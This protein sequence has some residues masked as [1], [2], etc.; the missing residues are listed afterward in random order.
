[1][2]EIL[3]W[4]T[5]CC[6]APQSVSAGLLCSKLS[7]RVGSGRVGV[8]CEWYLALTVGRSLSWAAT[9]MAD[10]PLA[11][12]LLTSAPAL[13]SDSTITSWPCCAASVSGLS[14]DS[15][16]LPA[17]NGVQYSSS[18]DASPLRELTCHM[19]SHSVR[20]WCHRLLA[21]HAASP[22]NR[23][24]VFGLKNYLNTSSNLIFK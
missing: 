23:N 5:I 3:R 13:S 7:S 15:K 22:N 2:S 16:H 18:Q 9:W 8:G 24:A 6:N 21:V 17:V 11:S 14:P 1:M 10:R 4:Y 20:T 19:G 12:S